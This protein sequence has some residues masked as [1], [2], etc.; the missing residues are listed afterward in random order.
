MATSTTARSTTARYEPSLVERKWQVGWHETDAF[1]TPALVEGRSDLY[2]FVGPP[3]IPEDSHLNHLRSYTLAD[4]HARFRRSSG[5]AV[6]F[7][8]GFEGVGL[9]A[10]LSDIAGNETHPDRRTRGDTQMREMLERL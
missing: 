2:V 9:R 10:E 6:L 4:S 8:F 5:D 3:P 7:A 1:A